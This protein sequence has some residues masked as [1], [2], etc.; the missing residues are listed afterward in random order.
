VIF[1]VLDYVY[2]RRQVRK[3][4]QLTWKRSWRDVNRAFAARDRGELS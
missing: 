3:Y 1:N 2:F 4:P